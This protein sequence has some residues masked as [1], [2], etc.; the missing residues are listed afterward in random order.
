MQN[1]NLIYNGTKKFLIFKNEVSNFIQI[2]LI[3]AFIC[4]F[5]YYFRVMQSPKR[6]KKKITLPNKSWELNKY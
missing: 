3:K 6:N 1:I 5:D 4:L 2:E